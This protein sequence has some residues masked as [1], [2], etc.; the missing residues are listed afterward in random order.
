MLVQQIGQPMT[1]ASTENARQSRLNTQKQPFIQLSNVKSR[2][3]LGHFI[4]KKKIAFLLLFFHNFAAEHQS[5]SKC[6]KDS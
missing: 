3:Y 6:E 1:K 5:L 2:R 4:K